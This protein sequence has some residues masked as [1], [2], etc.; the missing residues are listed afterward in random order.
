[1]GLLLEDSRNSQAASVAGTESWGGVGWGGGAGEPRV[2]GPVAAGGDMDIAQC[3][4]WEAAI[5]PK[6]SD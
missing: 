2:A 4:C 3:G 6:S 5:R 1:M